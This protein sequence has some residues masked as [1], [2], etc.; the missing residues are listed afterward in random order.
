MSVFK[1]FFGL[2]KIPQVIKFF[3]FES[4]DDVNKMGGALA[5][6]K[7]Q[8]REGGL[9]LTKAQEKYIEDQFE[10]VKMVFEKIQ[11]PTTETGIRG[12]QSAKIFDMEGQEIPQ[13]S[14]IMRG[15]AVDDTKMIDDAIENTSPGFVKGDTK[16]N[17]E[18]VAEDLAERMGLVYDDLDTRQRANIYGKAYDRLSKRNFQ[19]RQTE[20]QIAERLGRENKKAVGN[21]RKKKLRDEISKL[22]D[23]IEARKLQLEQ[24]GVEDFETDDLFNKLNE[25]RN[26]L[27][28][29]LD[30]EDM[31][32]PEDLA[33][34]GRVG[35]KT[36]MSKR[37]FLKLMGGAAAGI[38]A[39]KTGALKLFG[40]EGA[41]KFTTDIVTT[42]PVPGKPVWFDSLVNKVIRE[43]ND[44]TKRF[45]TKE[46]EIVHTKKID[47]DSTV[48][49]TQDLD[50][51]IVRVEYDSPTN[52]FED[53]VQLQYKKPLPDEGNPNPKAEFTT[54]E[55]GPVGRQ[56]SPDDYDIDIDEVG[57]TSIKDL[58]SDVS[59]LKEYATG[60]K[61]TLKEIVQNKKRR[62]KAQR[63]TDDPE[64]QSDAV[65]R[66][67]G[68]MLD[69]DGPDDDFASGGR[70]GLLSGGGLKGG[71]LLR[72][73]LQNLAEQY[74]KKPSELLAI[75]NYKSLPVEVKKFL[76]KE[77]FQAI[78]KDM[79]EMRVEQF[80]N[81][82]D[83]VENRQQFDKSREALKKMGLNI[84][85]TILQ[86]ETKAPV[87][88]GTTPDDLLMMEQII[89]NL[90]M[91]D[92]KLNASGG[93]AGMLGE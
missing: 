19:L 87:P 73:I 84:S 33:T 24:R 37:A 30:F 11:Q 43:G 86:A 85:D 55:S 76:T 53:T 1:A 50:E 61:P 12:T 79:Q 64:E 40:K 44:V 83:M 18:L 34:G 10:Q 41:K 66:R 65:V 72:V 56:V 82:R 23:K 60:Q 54:A 68:E 45:A 80:K 16:Y 20:K 35:L 2:G 58:D 90:Q 59:K 46:R 22:D 5:Q 14:K 77:Q 89:K 51:G 15:K 91:K 29:K 3:E 57:G 52:T 21:I 32:D 47:E 92:R 81:I 93:L 8:V 49:V 42:A 38:G 88:G 17:A 25:Q 28:I 7:Q 74:G 67:Q 27:E 4:F 48:T 63:I 36:G 6:I 78:K 39:L 31:V 62:D 26:D 70:V 75:T 13:G 69:Y 9:Q 71:G